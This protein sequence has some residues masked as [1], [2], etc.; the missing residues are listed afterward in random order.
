VAEV[1]AMTS[2]SIEQEEEKEEMAAHEEL[3]FY[4]RLSDLKAV[5]DNA[6]M[7][8]KTAFKILACVQSRGMTGTA[9]QTMRK[10]I[11]DVLQERFTFTESEDMCRVGVAEALAGARERAGIAPGK[12]VTAVLVG[13]GRTMG[14]NALKT[15]TYI[16]IRLVRT[17][18]GAK[19]D[20]HD[21]MPLAIINS[22]E[23][24]DMLATHMAPICAEMEKLQK[25]GEVEWCLGGDMK[26][27]NMV[28]GI[29]TA[30]HA[31][32]WR[33]GATA[34]TRGD[35]THQFATDGA[36][37]DDD[38]DE[39]EED[40][41][42]KHDL[43]PFIPTTH[44]MPDFLHL[45]LRIGERLLHLLCMKLLAAADCAEDMDDPERK[46]QAKFLREQLKEEF[47]KHT[48]RDV[49]FAKR[50]GTWQTSPKLTG[51]LLRPLLK[52]IDL[53][54]IEV[55]AKP[56]CSLIRE[57]L[58][59]CIKEFVAIHDVMN[60]P[61]PFGPKDAAHA[62]TRKQAAKDFQ[63]RILTWIHRSV[64]PSKQLGGHWE[65]KKWRDARD[66]KVGG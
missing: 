58:Q 16:C 2:T 66:E 10:A 51:N 22:G 32:A 13:D 8:D 9:L 40:I 42:L 20:K 26:W 6:A 47:L 53:K 34:K 17:G 33:C 45:H 52:N 63:N 31:C 55:F 60:T 57:G 24:Y 30:Q 4:E 50:D 18:K 64:A 37:D 62:P 43:F 49:E 29:S 12:K 38:G 15:T 27:I 7:S 36:S 25:K 46:S 11:D 39:G 35:Y 23:K 61:D 14:V 5:H 3:R 65:R 21:I 1:D 28:R 41:V 59:A 56:K 19:G 48:K 44:T 54:Q